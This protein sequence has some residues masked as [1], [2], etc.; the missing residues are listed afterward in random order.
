MVTR[1]RFSLDIVKSPQGVA[2]DGAL[3]LTMSRLNLALVTMA[4]LA[5]ACYKDDT[6]GPGVRSDDP[7]TDH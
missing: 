5:G 7:G 6:S 2:A 3:A 4:V 1:A